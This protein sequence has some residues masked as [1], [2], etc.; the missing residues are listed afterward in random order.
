MKRKYIISVLLASLFV[1]CTDK[2]E[3][4]NTDKKNPPVVPG[5]SLFTNGQKEL[6]DQVNQTSVNQ[7]VFK[8]WA[9]YW[10]E[11]TYID[12]ANYDIV[13]RN[14]PETVYRYYIRESL[15]DLTE[16]ARVISEETDPTT[17]STIQNRLMIIELLKA[18]AFQ[19]LVDIFGMIPY[20][21]ALNIDNV[22]PKYDD[23]A[24]VYSDLIAKVDAA[25]D[26][27]DANEE[28]FGS[29]DLFYGGDV[30][31]WI[32]FGNSLKIKLG[33]SIAD[34]NPTLAESTIVSAVDGAF[35]SEAD[36]CLIQY[37]GSSPNQNP[38]YQEIILTGRK[39]YVVANTFVD[40]LNALQDPRR[41]HFFSN[42][43]NGEYVG[44]IY[45]HANA[46]ANYSHISDGILQA[47]FPG[48]IMTYSE[49]L[50][51]LAE[52]AE[53]GFAVPNTAEE[54]YNM[55]ITSSI[56]SWG[57]TQADVDTYLARTDVAY[58]T[59]PD[60]SAEGWREKIGTQ[61]WIANYTKGLE[62]WTTWRRL[63]YPVFNVPEQWT[64]VMDIPTR[65]TFPVEEQ[66]LNQTKYGE[67]VNAMGGDELTIKIFW[68]K[69]DA[70]E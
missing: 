53:R 63:D 6:A 37:Q 42:K 26:G 45:G 25:I 19:Q 43:I 11:T 10:T 36:E 38:L 51:Y 33:I 32:K 58:A 64:S 57:G 4:F 59:A 49:I 14:I 48:F 56:L 31:K 22:Y 67:A 16:A 55:G 65:F 21:E 50:F 39:D 34:A 68:D 30:S 40:K 47:T 9:Q 5:N 52:A 28:S 8:L 62:A 18:Y 35:A 24:A 3:D 20:S 27:L 1:G 41:D 7:N 61:S 15:K 66:T 54:Y 60:A 2:F 69:F 29:A 46:Y 44:G 17:Q 13:T 12:E 70:N 23:G